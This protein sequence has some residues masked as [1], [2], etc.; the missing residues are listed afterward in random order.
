MSGRAVLNEAGELVAI[1]GQGDRDGEAG[2]GEKTG[3]NLGIV[4]ERFGT[5][6]SAMGVQLEQRVAA[7]PQSKRLNAEAYYYRGLLKFVEKIDRAG[8][9]QDLRQAARLYQDQGNTKGYLKAKSHV[10]DLD[11]IDRLDR[12]NRQH[13]LDIDRLN[14]G[15][16]ELTPWPL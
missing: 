11:R 5:V 4:V 3:R 8:S 6:A 15:Q 1:H 14:N 16:R 10:D 12:N 9:I 13:Q 2:E 7:L